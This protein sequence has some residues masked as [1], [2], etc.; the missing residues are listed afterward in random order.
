MEHYGIRGEPLQIFSQ[1]LSNR[2][3]CTKINTTLSEPRT[4]TCGIPQGS[5]LGPL[6]FNLYVNDL[7]KVTSLQTIL[8]A[9]DTVL[10]QSN[11]CSKTLE[12]D[13]NVGTAAVD[14]WLRCNKLTLNYNKTKF[15]LFS[16]SKKT[17]FAEFNVKFTG[18]QIQQT[19]EIKYLGMI[20]DDKLTW[21]GHTKH[22]RTKV[23]RSVGL[24]SK[25][26]HYVNANALKTIYY[27]LVHSHLSYGLLNWGRAYETHLKPLNV[28]Q[29]KAIKYMTYSNQRTHS[30]PLYKRLAILPIIELHKFEIL[31]FM[32]KYQHDKLP[33]TFSN[34]LQ[35]LSNI[36]K[37]DTRQ[38]STQ[39]YHI[40]SVR[41]NAGKK[42]LQ[43]LGPVEWSK[44][45]K[46]NKISNLS[47]KS[48]TKKIKTFLLALIG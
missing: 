9:D 1:Y 12:R 29:N 4:V 8:F 21:A 41:T 19:C 32:H 7:P 11:K 27:A 20:L 24:L 38:K 43:F 36:H 13:I 3:Q 33:S 10:Y 28:L 45:P 47:Y 31:K 40:N 26:R 15:M 23:A 22:V 17:D 16:N 48:F 42:T 46:E 6:L 5:V 18:I 39:V 34:L 44:I 37:H 14:D 35:P 25:M 30:K 2:K